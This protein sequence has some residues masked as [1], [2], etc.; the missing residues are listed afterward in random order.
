MALPASYSKV[1]KNDRLVAAVSEED[2][3]YSRTYFGIPIQSSDRWRLDLVNAYLN[4][5]LAMYCFFMTATR[6]GVDKQIAEQND[7]D[8][9]P[10]SDG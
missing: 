1:Y 10:V 6:F 5:S 7:F 4:S 3:V 2:L 9:L 8:R